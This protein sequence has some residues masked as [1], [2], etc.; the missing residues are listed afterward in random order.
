MPPNNHG[1]RRSVR[2]MADVLVLEWLGCQDVILKPTCLDIPT[3]VG[4]VINQTSQE[5]K[6]LNTIFCVK[7]QD[8]QYP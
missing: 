7:H 4:G 6:M 2:L 3:R 1:L 8:F 5:A